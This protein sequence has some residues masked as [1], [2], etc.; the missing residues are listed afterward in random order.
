MTDDVA[1]FQLRYYDLPDD[2]AYATA[3]S[4]NSRIIE[5]ILQ[6]LGPGDLLAARMAPRN[7]LFSGG[8]P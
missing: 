8:T 2:V 5:V 7:I 3:W 6:G 4:T 1:D